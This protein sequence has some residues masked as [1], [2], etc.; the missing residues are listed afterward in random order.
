MLGYYHIPGKIQSQSKTL[1]LLKQSRYPNLLSSIP[2]MISNFK[3]TA[4]AIAVFFG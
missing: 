3:E 1:K 2:L 4:R